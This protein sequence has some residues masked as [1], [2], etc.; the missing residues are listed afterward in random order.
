MTPVIEQA[1]PAAAAKTSSVTLKEAVN[2]A[3]RWYPSVAQAVGKLQQDTVGIQAARGGYYPKIRGGINTGY[4]GTYGAQP[5]FN[6]TASQMIYDFGKISSGVDAAVADQHISQSLVLLAVDNIVRDTAGAVIEVQRFRGLSAAAQAQLK[7]VQA[8]G[9]LVTERNDKGASTKSDRVQ[10]QARVEAARSTILETEG[11]LSRWESTLANLTGGSSNVDPALDAPIWLTQACEVNEPDW[12]RVPV[13]LQAEAEQKAALAQLN[14][15]R[16]E[17]WPT[18]SL[19]ANS[20]YDFGQGSN[21]GTSDLSYKVGFNVT[22]DL[23]EGGSASARARAARYGLKSADAAIRNARND[24]TR[25]L[26]E[27]R[28]QTASMNQLLSSLASRNEIMSQTRDLYQTQYTQ[29]GTRTLLDLLNAEQELYE[30]QFNSVNTTYDLRHLYVDCLV[31]S[32]LARKAFDID[33]NA[34]T[35]TSLQQ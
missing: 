29:L 35:N 3:V 18:V 23:Y 21:S 26:A 1:K 12:A 10:A 22:G 7:N 32:G 16:A 9:E 24:A 2:R 33:E 11:K 34:F 13:V 8:I 4:D 27:A 17:V 31:N 14:L 25:G 19:E 20:G 30:A 5:N 15:S 28:A 6:L